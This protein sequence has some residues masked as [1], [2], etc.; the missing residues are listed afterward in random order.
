MRQPALPAGHPMRWIL[1]AFT[2]L[3]VLVCFTTK[4]PGL[5]GLCLFLGL[6][7]IIA[8]A[9]AFAQERIEGNAKPE[10]LNAYEMK[11]LR[12]SIAKPPVEKP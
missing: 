8:T 3:M 12:D 10:V 11:K 4:S 7:G 1:A 2:A 9:L 6:A 5:L